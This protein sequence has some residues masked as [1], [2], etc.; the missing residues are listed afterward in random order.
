M[1]R[2]K[3]KRIALAGRR[4]VGKSTLFNALLG[5]KRAITD[6]IPGLTRDILEAEIVR[7]PYHFILSDTPGL[8]IEN[9][10]DL[11]A[12]ILDRAKKYIEEVDGIIL[13]LDATG[14]TSFDQFYI[15]F[16]RKNSGNRPVFYVVNKCDNPNR[17]VEYLADI[18][19][20]GVTDPIVVSAKGRRN[21]F[22]LL[23]KVAKD[24]P[25]IKSKTPA[26]H[27]ETEEEASET[28]SELEEDQVAAG[29]VEMGDE[30]AEEAEDEDEFEGGL[31]VI[32]VFEPSAEA[33]VKTRKEKTS[34]RPEEKSKKNIREKKKRKTGADSS[35]MSDEIET[36]TSIAI[37]GRPNSGKSSILNRI[38]QKDVSLVSDVPGTT[39]DTVDSIITYYNKDIRIIDTAGLRKVQRLRGETKDVEFFSL[40][41]TRRAI[42][43]S[44]IVVHVI[45][46]T[47]GVTDFDKKISSMVLEYGKPIVF[48]INKWDAVSDK[49]HKTTKE[50]LDRMDFIFPYSAKYP[51][52]FVSAM[53]GQRIGKIL[54]TCVMLEEKICFRI[55]TGKLNNLVEAWNEYLRGYGHTARIL[56]ATQADAEPPVFIFFVRNKKD[57]K[58]S[59]MN[60]FENKLR[61]EFDLQGIPVRIILRESD[62]K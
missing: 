6:N 60:Y 51:R 47:M 42:Q 26:A 28:Q 12:R 36:M 53:T 20:A 40:S 25:G 41:R 9:P 61:K 17:D 48:A 14:L 1:K 11:E 59:H 7:P 23:K 37:V 21:I 44:R 30:I 57:F 50:F 19:E 46:A 8:D 22:E 38:V 10:D 16:F 2:K 32:H 13:L 52:I 34:D 3:I 15:D 62:K 58:S 45:D 4:N 54:E 35:V 29:E 27:E 55:T 39:R 31:E 33:M 24:I 49:T 18:Y 5:R 56:Y 43:D